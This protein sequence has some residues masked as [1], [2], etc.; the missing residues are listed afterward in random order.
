MSGSSL[1]FQRTINFGSCSLKKIQK[2]ENCCFQLFQK[3][4]KFDS[5]HEKFDKEPAIFFLASSSSFSTQKME[6][7]SYIPKLFL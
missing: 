5:F 3:N 7:G 2:S 4:L 1:N 6:N